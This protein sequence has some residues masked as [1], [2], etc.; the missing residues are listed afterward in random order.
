MTEFK[1]ETG[2]DW[3][4]AATEELRGVSLKNRSPYG[5]CEDAS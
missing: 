2:K 3:I 1:T 4:E 5:C